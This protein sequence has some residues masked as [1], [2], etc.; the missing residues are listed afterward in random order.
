MRLVRR[1]FGIHP[2]YW[3]GTQRPGLFLGGNDL[4]GEVPAEL[5][6]LTTAEELTRDRNRLTGQLPAEMTSLTELATF[7]FGTNAGLCA[8]GDDDFLQAWPDGI[9]DRDD[10]PTCP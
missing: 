9:P 3:P 8:P 4:S 2:T 5:G 6:A 7:R 1:A 10:G